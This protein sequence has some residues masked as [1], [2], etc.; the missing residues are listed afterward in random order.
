MRST[1][2]S[3]RLE[4]VQNAI[5]SL[6]TASDFPNFAQTCFNQDKGSSVVRQNYGFPIFVPESVIMVIVL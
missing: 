6:C 1:V 4:L 5:V 2:L 3:L